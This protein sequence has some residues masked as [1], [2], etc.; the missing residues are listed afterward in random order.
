MITIVDYGVGNLRSVVNMLRKVGVDCRVSGERQDIAE[1]DKL[2]LPGVGHFR[3]GMERLHSSGL[4]DC[5]NEFALEKRKP[6]LGICLGA[7]IL[8]KG[9]DEAPNVEGLGW[10]DMHCHR[11]P[12]AEGFRV[13]HMGWSD[14]EPVLE[15][16][17]LSLDGEKQRFYFVHSFYM[18]CERQGD[19]LAET[20]YGFRYTCAVW[21]ENIIGTQFHPEKSHRF[22]MEL[23]RRFAAI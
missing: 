9:S 15:N 10:V 6:V 20:E 4:V 8:G 1:A 12:K 5:L 7:Q 14:V 2:I 18:L 23:M 17:L 22:G 21:N 13:P 3:H 16:S 19:I 11:F